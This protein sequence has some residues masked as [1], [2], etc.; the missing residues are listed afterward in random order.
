M[1]IHHLKNPA[2][3]QPAPPNVS[4]RVAIAEVMI[5]EILKHFNLRFAISVIKV[6]GKS[7][8]QEIVLEER[9]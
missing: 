1:S 7:V 4:E 8:H 9:G 5:E 2:E 6:D 3:Y